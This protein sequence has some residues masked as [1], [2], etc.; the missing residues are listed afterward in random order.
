VPVDWSKQ[1][2]KIEVHTPEGVRGATVVTLPFVDP[3]KT[4]ARS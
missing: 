1:G 2:T 3:N 4:L